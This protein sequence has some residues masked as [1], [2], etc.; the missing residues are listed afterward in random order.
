MLE[1]GSIIEFHY[2]RTSHILHADRCEKT[3]RRVLVRSVRDLVREPLTP[4][5][6]LRRPFILRSRWMIRGFDLDR[7]RERSFYLGSSIEFAAPNELRIGEYAPDHHWPD[8][9]LFR[10]IAATLDDRRVLMRALQTWRANDYG[11]RD[12]RIY[13]DDLR[14]I[15]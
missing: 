13:A 7:R 15:A 10:P 6:F 14:L 1:I 8:A 2:P 3:L 12:L 9:V 4:D 11:G 5:D